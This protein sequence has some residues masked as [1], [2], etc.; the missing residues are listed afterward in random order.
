MPSFHLLQSGFMFL[1]LKSFL[2][3][4][5]KPVCKYVPKRSSAVQTGICCPCSALHG[6]H[7]YPDVH[8]PAS[9]QK[10]TPELAANESE[11]TNKCKDR[12]ELFTV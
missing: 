1:A 6:Q 9:S 4:E 5:N 2:P 3:F 11:N 8:D 7:L 10:G 12:C